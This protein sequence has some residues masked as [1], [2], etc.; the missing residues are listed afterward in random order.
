VLTTAQP[1][2]GEHLQ[3]TLDVRVTA[4]ASGDG[5]LS[6]VPEQSLWKHAPG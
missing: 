4:L 2:V 5:E 3:S 1:P 6:W